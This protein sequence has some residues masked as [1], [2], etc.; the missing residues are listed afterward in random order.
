MTVGTWMLAPQCFHVFGALVP[1]ADFITAS[2]PGA[3]AGSLDC[4]D[5]VRRKLKN[6]K[7]F[8]ISDFSDFSGCSELFRVIQSVSLF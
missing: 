7:D 3:R 8:M 5:E 6:L 2:W 1:D 4:F